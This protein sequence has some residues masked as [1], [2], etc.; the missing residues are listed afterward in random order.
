MGRTNLSKRGAN[1]KRITDKMRIF[2]FEY[3]IDFDNRRAA[4]AAGYPKRSASA[5]ACKLLKHPVI[6]AIVAKAQRERLEGCE[7]ESKRVLQELVYCALRDPIDLCDEHGRIAVDD[8]NQIPEQIRRCIDSFKI[9]R[10]TDKKTGD[11]RDV[12]EL[13]LTS[14]LAAIELAMKHLGLFAAEKHELKQLIDWDQL[15]SDS[16][17][18]NGSLPESPVEERLRLEDKSDE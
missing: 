3:L 17:E 5:I 11:T 14:K 18:G 4:I 1:P 16:G 12:I 8:L 15:Y 9:T 10:Y 6:K 2:A 13:K 7:L